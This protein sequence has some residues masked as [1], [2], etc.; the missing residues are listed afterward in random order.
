MCSA[1]LDELHAEGRTIVLITHEHDVA[2]PR[3]AGRA[4]PRRSGLARRRRGPRPGGAGAGRCAMRWQDTV[5]TAGDAV[6]SH[7][8][9]SALTMLGILI[10]IT[11]VVLTVGLGAGAR[12]DIQ[13][14]DRRAGHQRPGRLAR[15]LHRLQRASVAGSAPRRRSRRPTPRRSTPTSPAPDV[16]AVAPVSTTSASLTAG[17]DQLDDD[18]DRH[19]RVL[20]DGAL[21]RG[22]LGSLPDRRG[23]GVRRGRWSCSAPTPPR[24]CSARPT[25][26]A[27]PSSY[28][29][30]TLEVVG[31][32]E[33]AVLVGRHDEQRHG[34]RPAQ[35]LRAATRR[36]RRPA[37]RS[38]RST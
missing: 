29:G 10:G 3:P 17:T 28:D 13:D 8:L 7:R 26:S 31:V 35:H 4:D 30:T 18:P 21:P 11:A 24:S 36:R 16:V 2:G 22:R 1:L 20:A 19:D 5:R 23:R 12:A 38:A 14:A 27:R 9:R 15:Q 34:D 33:R 6:R 25:R 37:T 32:L